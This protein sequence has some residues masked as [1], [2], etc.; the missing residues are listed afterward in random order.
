MSSIVALTLSYG[1]HN[2]R[3]LASDT[4]LIWSTVASEVLS[5]E[6]RLPGRLTR[7]KQGPRCRKHGS[8]KDVMLSYND[9]SVVLV[10]GE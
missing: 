9:R 6:D 4:M 2:P 1:A 3:F 10:I 7:E 5:A 8:D